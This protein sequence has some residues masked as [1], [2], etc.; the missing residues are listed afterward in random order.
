MIKIIISLI[1]ITASFNCLSQDF[2]ILNAQ[3]SL[4]FNLLEK[5]Y[6]KEEF[7]RENHKTYNNIRLRE[8]DKILSIPIEE[9]CYKIYYGQDLFKKNKSEGEFC[10]SIL[11][12]QGHYE[13]AKYLSKIKLEE[14]KY[15][16][17]AFFY[18]VMKSLTQN[19]FPSIRKP[20]EKHFKDNPKIDDEDT[21][22][23]FY[24]KGL[25]AGKNLNFN[26]LNTI[27]KDWTSIVLFDKSYYKSNEIDNNTSKLIIY[28]E[29]KEFDKFVDLQKNNEYRGS[30]LLLLAQSGSENLKKLSEYC[31]KMNKK[32]LSRSCLQN[33]YM[34][35]KNEIPL[36]RFVYH[37]VSN[38]DDNS[39]SFQK[40]I[41]LLGFNFNDFVSRRL[42]NNIIADN[43]DSIEKI[44]EIIFYY[45]MG[46]IKRINYEKQRQKNNE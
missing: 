31:F 39:V 29:E 43:K 20:L 22:M 9:I 15:K 24:D 45:N 16:E 46:K 44:E 42:L 38:Q 37:L 6:N 5:K 12:N 3:N 36:N 21:F 30:M 1:L 23:S 7:V 14:K 13:G 41:E 25:Y 8:R 33:I 34:Y 26:F 18:G 40:I 2:K 10:L 28:L 11:I 32:H 19:D 27:N 17:S 4:A 35:N